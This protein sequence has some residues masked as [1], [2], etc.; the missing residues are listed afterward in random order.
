MEDNK[1]N[2]YQYCK[3]DLVR[4]QDQF[5]SLYIF[6]GFLSEPDPKED[7]DEAIVQVVGDVE[8]SDFI[9]HF[10]DNPWCRVVI[11]NIDM[12]HSEVRD[13]KSG[14]YSVFTR[15]VT[16]QFRIII[17]FG[18]DNLLSPWNDMAII[19]DNEIGHELHWEFIESSLENPWDRVIIVGIN[20]I[21][22][23]YW[24]GTI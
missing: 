18:G 23:S 7:M 6:R 12:L 11:T 2:N 13:D 8:Y 1:P 22:D 3:I 9:E 19:V 24:H 4:K 14:L 5:C 10:L 17:L 15:E 16:S 21:P 20:E